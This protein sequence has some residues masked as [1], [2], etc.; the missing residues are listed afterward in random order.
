VH[1]LSRQSQHVCV[2][3]KVVCNTVQS[4]EGCKPLSCTRVKAKH[5]QDEC[6]PTEIT[7]CTCKI[8]CVSST[9]ESSLPGQ[10]A[11][12]LGIGSCF[13]RCWGRCST[14]PH[15]KSSVCSC[16]ISM[17]VKHSNS[18]L[19]SCSMMGTAVDVASQ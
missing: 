5:E 19:V 15:A 11:A 14:A 7:A 16:S 17:T 2:S 8:T 18:F 12:P 4:P 6:I 9:N 13:T 3:A 1:T 10:F